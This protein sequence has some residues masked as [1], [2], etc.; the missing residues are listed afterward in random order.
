MI[1]GSSAKSNA[2]LGFKQSL[3]HFDYTWFVFNQ[4]SHYCSSY[5]HLTTGVK[6]GIRSFGVEFFTRSLPCF[7]KLHKQFYNNNLKIIPKDIYN[8]LSPIALA[9]WI[10]GD[11][12]YYKGGGIAICTD[13]YSIQ[14]VVRLMNVLVIRYGLKCTL[15]TRR[16]GQYRIFISKKSMESLITIIKPHTTPSMYYKIH[17]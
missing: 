16:E 11:G 3:S 5:P 8:L 1:F 2:R 7:T 17:S 12:V 10:M 14:D 6:K 9:H 15:Q 4:L 13:S